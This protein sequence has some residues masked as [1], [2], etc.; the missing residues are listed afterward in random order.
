MPPT[1]TSGAI[2]TPSDQNALIDSCPSQPDLVI[3]PP[4]NV[5]ARLNRLELSTAL[6]LHFFDCF[7]H[8]PQA[9]LPIFPF[10]KLRSLVASTPLPLLPS[11][12]SCLVHAI[13]ATASLISPD[14]SVVGSTFSRPTPAFPSLGVSTEGDGDPETQDADFDF[15]EYGRMRESVCRT[16]V[17]E[18]RSMAVREGVT[19]VVTLENSA[20]CHLLDLLDV[21]MGSPGARVFG[22]AFVAMTR[23]LAEAGVITGGVQGERVKW[24]S[25]LMAE[26]LSATSR[27]HPILLSRY[28]VDLVCGDDVDPLDELAR[29]AMRSIGADTTRCFICFRPFVL[30]VIRLA[31]EG[32]ELFIGAPAQRKPFQ[33]EKYSHHLSSLVSLR[34]LLEQIVLCSGESTNVLPPSLR[35]F[36]SR[37]INLSMTLA[38][39]SLLLSLHHALALRLTATQ[40]CDENGWRTRERLDLL[41]AQTRKLTLQAAI[42][43]ANSAEQTSSVFYLTHIVFSRLEEWAE[44]LVAEGGT[45]RIAG[46]EMERITALRRILRAL[47]RAGWSYVDRTGVVEAVELCLELEASETMTQGGGFQ[48]EYSSDLV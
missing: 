34:A 28:D 33:E 26:A 3:L 4:D 23:F 12:T 2:S 36:F 43:V 6:M 44:V 40:V 1:Q 21:K 27:R 35:F 48:I 32:F 38:W 31:R 39:G 9:H 29:E 46:L 30:H 42:M 15:R 14:P 47:K 41:M 20:T 25:I 8:L 10:Q 17:E 5:L 24:S 37:A 19:T 11:S 45:A 13:L 22:S 7:S 16:L 18:A